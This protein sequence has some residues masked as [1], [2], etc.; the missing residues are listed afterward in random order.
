MHIPTFV[1]I[2]ILFRKNILLLLLYPKHVIKLL[3]CNL[4]CYTSLD[5]IG[6]T[7]QL[8]I[9]IRGGWVIRGGRNSRGGRRNAGSNVRSLNFYFIF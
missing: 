5:H 2:F 1:F 9:T 4:G 8:N 7:T 6:A 3:G